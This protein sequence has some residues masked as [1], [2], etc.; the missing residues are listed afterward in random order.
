M[1]LLAFIFIYL[2][3]SLYLINNYKDFE[4]EIILSNLSA[5]QIQKVFEKRFGGTSIITWIKEKISEAEVC[6]KSAEDFLAS[7][8][9]D[10]EQYKMVT[11]HLVE[12]IRPIK[13]LVKYIRF[14]QEAHLIT[15]IESNFYE[16]NMDKISTLVDKM[17]DIS[18]QISTRLDTPSTLST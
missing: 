18:N 6:Y 16:S 4:N 9:A 8:S 13:T 12:M 3:Y 14:I 11:K 5:E 10:K 2:L 17:E 7:N 1:L 15:E